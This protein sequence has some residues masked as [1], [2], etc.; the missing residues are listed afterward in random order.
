MNATNPVDPDEEHDE[1]EAELT[2][3]GAR[4]YDLRAARQYFHSVRTPGVYMSAEELAEL[5][6]HGLAD[7][8][9]I[10]LPAGEMPL[11]S[12]RIPEI[13]P[14]PAASAF[15]I[16][17]G[18]LRELLPPQRVGLAEPDA[19]TPEPER[20]ES[21]PAESPGRPEGQ[22]SGA[23]VPAKRAVLRGQV[24]LHRAT[25]RALPELKPMPTWLT[26][27][28]VTKDTA[29]WAIRYA[30][31]YALI[32]ARRGP[33]HG[34]RLARLGVAGIG[35]VL[36]GWGGWAWDSA[37]G[38]VVH[39]LRRD[40][41]FAAREHRKLTRRFSSSSKIAIEQASENLRHAKAQL[42]IARKTAWSTRTWRLVG[43]AIPVGA[44]AAGLVVGEQRI[45]AVVPWVAAATATLAVVLM[46][47]T[48]EARRRAELAEPEGVRLVNAAP[49]LELGMPGRYVADLLV[50]EFADLRIEL[51]GIESVTQESWGWEVT[52]L[53]AKGTPAQLSAVLTDLET[54]LASPKD[55]VLM[56]PELA[57]AARVVLRIVW[58]DPFANMG[59]AAA[60]KVGAGLATRSKLGM[61][62]TGAPLELSFLGVNAL[63][64]GVSRSGKSR[65]LRVVVDA[66]LASGDAIVADIDVTG[67]SGLEA[68]EKALYRRGLDDE[69]AAALL[70]FA[71]AVA[72]V[73][74]KMF[75]RLGMGDVWKASAKYP[76]FVLVIDE[77]PR[78][79]KENKLLA[80]T[81]VRIGLKAR[82]QI[83]FASQEATKDALGSA[84]AD[85][86]SIAAMLASRHADIPLVLGEGAIAG[87]WRPDK[88]HPAEGEEAHDAGRA[89]IRSGSL[90]T[91][92]LY[93]FSDMSG[94]AAEERAASYLAAGIPGELDQE[95]LDAVRALDPR[96]IPQR[97]AEETID[98]DLA[99]AAEIPDILAD[100][101]AAFA[102]A[103][104]ETMTPAGLVDELQKREQRWAGLSPVVLGRKMAGLGLPSS[105]IGNERG[106][107]ID[108]LRAL[109]ARI[110]TERAN[111][112]A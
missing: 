69:A 100:I 33:V 24:V 109:A 10:V 89:Y 41:L 47:R 25:G 15:E 48:A 70:L 49:V 105:P 51:R 77:F 97:I 76:A 93:K 42:D 57:N 84:I 22:T 16:P 68:Q 72:E 90:N 71:I 59:P 103:G 104:A 5:Q 35:A 6:A 66:I 34:W 32:H 36:R 40:V 94:Q 53:M 85:S 106:W 20:P 31:R 58:R 50:K 8:D 43:S 11:P 96:I 112:A 37:D 61:C 108:D 38:A 67:G 73:R 81:L 88:L 82:V 1:A 7:T 29:A 80:I 45:G 92:L 95:T 79:A 86:I 56:Q 17:Q 54:R 91:P 60:R 39:A 64:I 21:I 83:I 101:L 14:G 55:A 99:E 19:A 2:E 74:T 28:Q 3:S 98:V 78:L 27:W 46:G 18:Y 62:M 65:A 107:R 23:L 26:D 102:A 9:G 110:R 13:A 111:A 12:P 44:V 52:M 4:V 75:R 63:F 87:G 30:G